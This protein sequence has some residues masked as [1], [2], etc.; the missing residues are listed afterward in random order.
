[1]ELLQ[2]RIDAAS[3]YK[4]IAEMS[5]SRFRGSFPLSTA[6]HCEI[7]L[8]PPLRFA[9]FVAF[10]PSALSTPMK[11]TDPIYL[12]NTNVIK[13]ESSNSKSLG[14]SK[15]LKRKAGNLNK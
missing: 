14:E 11:F 15:R 13:I 8:P 12:R 4:T 2:Y 5:H 6:S 1:M 3:Y 7:K 9:H 10:F